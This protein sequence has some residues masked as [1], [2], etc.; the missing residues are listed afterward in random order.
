MISAFT[1]C[2]VFLSLLSCLVGL[3]LWLHPLDK[4]TTGLVMAAVNLC[5]S[6]IWGSCRLSRGLR[7][8]LD[9][10][11]GCEA[12]FAL[13]LPQAHHFGHSSQK[14]VSCHSFWPLF[15]YQEASLQSLASARESGSV[16]YSMCNILASTIPLALGPW[17]WPDSPLWFSVSSLSFPLRCLS[18]CACVCVCACVF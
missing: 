11:L 2:S 1:L 10:V 13:L 17:L 16:L 12:V 8:Q 3:V 18:W 9:P 7:G 6:L 14:L 15:T 5:S 4:S